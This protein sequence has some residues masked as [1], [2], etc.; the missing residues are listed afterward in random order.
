[1]RVL[2][3]GAVT[4]ILFLGTGCQVAPPTPPGPNLS[5]SLP[6]MKSG[7][8]PVGAMYLDLRRHT[9]NMRN[10]SISQVSVSKDGKVL[11]YVK[12]ELGGTSQI[13]MKN[14]DSVAAQ[15]LTGNRYTNYYPRLSPNGKYVAFASNRNGNWDVFIIRADAPS[16]LIQVT[17][18]HTDD[19][20]PS[21]SPDGNQLVYCSKSTRGI[22]QI[23]L[24]DWRTSIPTILG[25]GLYPDWGPNGLIAFQSQP[26]RNDR[27]V[28]VQIV[29]PDGTNLR[30]VNF[31]R[32]GRYSAALPRWSPD[33]RYLVFGVLQ[34]N[35]VEI[36]YRHGRSRDL[37]IVR[38]DGSRPMQLTTGELE[39]EWWP[40]WGADRI[41]FVSTREGGYSNVYSFKPRM[42]E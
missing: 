21:W 4:A 11:L 30:E 6:G 13:F 33:G 42:I 37:W 31:D 36:H 38:A 14:A 28:G 18:G 41:F 2:G 27:R 3:I 17:R 24:V 9:P 26:G 39:D 10:A 12:S 8:L 19:I 35:A 22:W 29:K 23:V 34:G 25:P 7:P 16:T 32:E 1:M 40:S 15:Q 5:L 20:A